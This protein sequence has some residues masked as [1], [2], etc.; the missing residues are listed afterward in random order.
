MA[1]NTHGDD[2]RRR[3]TIV[4]NNQ[5]T[6]N[7]AARRVPRAG[8]GM[9]PGR[10]FA[11]RGLWRLVRVLA[12][13]CWSFSRRLLVVLLVAAP[14]SPVRAALPVAPA[15]GYQRR[16]VRAIADCLTDR[17][18]GGSCSTRTYDRRVQE[19]Q[20]MNI[21]RGLACLPVAA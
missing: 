6:R 5:P 8:Q 1:V 18:G 14:A 10:D 4:E 11:E 20:T 19:W 12:R 17:L 7:T 21:L 2:Q 15:V 3:T 9:S 13:A 16:V